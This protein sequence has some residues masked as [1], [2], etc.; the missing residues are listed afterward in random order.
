MDSE[1]EALVLAPFRSRGFR[2][3]AFGIV[4][5]VVVSVLRYFL[6][7]VLGV[8]HSFSL[9]FL[10]VTVTAWTGGLWPTIVIALVSA[11][12]GDF[13]FSE[14]PLSFAIDTPEELASLVI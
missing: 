11:L 14:P 10:A 12:A 4:G 9:Y 13:F 6:S 2:P 7:E 5:V 8:H 1:K 3:Y